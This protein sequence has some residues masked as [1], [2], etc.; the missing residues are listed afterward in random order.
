VGKKG[1]LALHVSQP[2]RSIAVSPG[3]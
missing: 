1:P 3:S 2:V